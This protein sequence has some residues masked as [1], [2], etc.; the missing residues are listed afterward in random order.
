[1]DEAGDTKRACLHNIR[2]VHHP[3]LASSRETYCVPLSGR[4]A[5]SRKVES[6]QSEMHAQVLRQCSAE[7]Q[8][9]AHSH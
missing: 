8:S 1:M 9:V 4:L 5:G 7:G 3:Q 6:E 2:A